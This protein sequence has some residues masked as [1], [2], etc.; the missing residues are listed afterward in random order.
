MFP[1][2]TLYDWISWNRHRL[3]SSG[4]KLARSPLFFFNAV[5]CQLLLGRI[6]GLSV[7]V[8]RIFSRHGRF[9]GHGVGV[10]E[11][12]IQSSSSK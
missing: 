11:T 8:V 7:C 6:E 10:L 9:I 3:L 4:D 5:T 2:A 12:F 1:F